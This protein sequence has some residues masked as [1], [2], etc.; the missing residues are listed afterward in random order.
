MDDALLMGVLNRVADGNEQFES[1]FGCEAVVVAV[2]R[3]GD[4]LDQ[5]HDEVGRRPSVAPAS[6]TLAMFGW[7]MRARAWRSASKRAMTCRLSM[8]GLMILRA[9][10]RRTRLLLLGHEDDAHAAF[11]DLLQEFVRADHRAGPLRQRIIH[12]GPQAGRAD[13]FVDTA[14]PVV[15]REQ[16]IDLL[17]QPLITCTGLVKVGGTFGRR[18]LFDSHLK[19]RFFR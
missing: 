12:G 18:S 17:A 4:A 16:V 1:L 19:D 7:S 15:H 3:D 10:L 2:L 13:V 11:A 6:S 8:P 14:E 9:T 5:F